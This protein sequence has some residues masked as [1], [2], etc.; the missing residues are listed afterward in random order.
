[1][2]VQRWT[3]QTTWDAFLVS[4]PHAPFQ[5]AWV[6]GEFKGQIGTEVLRFAAVDGERIV[7]VV[8]ALHEPWRF[9]QSTLT[10]FSGPVV[11]SRLPVAQYQ[12]ALEALL[13]MLVEEAKQRQVMLLHVEAPIAQHQE[14]LLKPLFGAHKLKKAAPFQPLDTQVLDLHQAE[15][16]LLAGMHE[17][18]R[19]NIRLAEKRGVAARFATG[20]GAAAALEQFIHLNKQTAAR[21]RFASHASAY[22]RRLHEYLG[23][24][25]LRVYVATYEKQPIAANIVVHFGD[26]ATYVHGASSNAN[27]NVMAPH[28]L[29]WEQIVDAKLA[30]KSWYDLYGIQTAQRTRASKHGASWAGITRFKVG[31]GGQTISYLDAHELLVRRGWYRLVKVYRRFF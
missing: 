9:G 5:Q 29:Q 12:A 7:G 3:D 2:N 6:W 8:Q 13:K 16:A 26:T 25:M 19:Y 21:D 31:F 23:D 20:A 17:K 4:Q 15:T 27:R 22:Y 14:S 11:D 10:V 28:L 1:M 18:T 24:D 30:W